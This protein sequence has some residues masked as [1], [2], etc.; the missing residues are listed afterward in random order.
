MLQAL[1]NAFMADPF[2]VLL[3]S[4]GVVGVV[5]L[6]V[7][8]WRGRA[9]PRVRLLGHTYE[10]NGTYECPTEVRVEIENVGRE[11][12]SVEPTVTM[13]CRY[14]K[15]EKIETTFQVAEA[16]R[17]LPPVTPKTFVLNGKPPVGYIFSHFRDY[18]LTFTRG[19]SV[20]LRVLNAS[21]QTAG[22]LKFWLIKW[23]YILTGALPHV[24][25]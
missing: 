3:G 8:W 14:V 16:D 23:L 18:Q 21:G 17:M 1:L 19:K 6:V 10:P 4:G 20:H 12:T 22:P 9:L 2:K 11:S 15:K 5:V 7:K 24:E 13:A 25:G